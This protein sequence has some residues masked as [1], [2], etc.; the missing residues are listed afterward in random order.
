MK[1]ALEPIQG[2]VAQ[3]GQTPSSNGLFLAVLCIFLSCA[4][5]FHVYNLLME[6]HIERHQKEIPVLI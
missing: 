6:L 4:Q 2:D 1:H 3:A 5:C